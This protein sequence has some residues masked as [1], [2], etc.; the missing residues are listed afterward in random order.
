MYVAASRCAVAL[1]FCE[2]E[3]EISLSLSLSLS[4]ARPRA[5]A[6]GGDH[7]EV[8]SPG[9][10]PLPASSDDRWPALLNHCHFFVTPVL[11]F[12]SAPSPSTPADPLGTHSAGPQ[13]AG[14]RCSI[15]YQSTSRGSWIARAVQGWDAK[16]RC[17]C[18]RI[19]YAV[20]AL[21]RLLPLFCLTK[22]RPRRSVLPPC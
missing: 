16:V 15:G 14:R 20:V 21:S 13:P 10:S 9:K 1:H 18:F 17:R 6:M 5:A 11:L 12:S 4:A 22:C 7:S 2:R 19:S 8:R 3:L